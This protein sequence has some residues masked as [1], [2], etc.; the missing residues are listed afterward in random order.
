MRVSATKDLEA[1]TPITPVMVFF[2]RTGTNTPT[3]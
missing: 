1:G 2:E 3:I